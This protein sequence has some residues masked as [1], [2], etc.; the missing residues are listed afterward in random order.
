M[1]SVVWRTF[2]IVGVVCLVGGVDLMVVVLGW[3]LGWV[4]WFSGRVGCF[5]F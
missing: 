3:F 5:L 4:G 2:V 1:K